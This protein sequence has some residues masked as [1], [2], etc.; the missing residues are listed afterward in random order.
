MPTVSRPN[1]IG[2]TS[3]VIPP[4]RLPQPAVVA[5]AVPTQFEANISVVWYCVMTKL[6]P[7]A[8]IATRN[9]RNDS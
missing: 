2:M 4:P 7:I 3:C 5:L 6:A 9:Q 8:P 1:S